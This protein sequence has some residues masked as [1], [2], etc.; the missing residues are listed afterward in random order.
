M[1]T[2]WAITTQS[3]HPLIVD[4][5]F[6]KLKLIQLLVGKSYILDLIIVP[7]S[8]IKVL[9]QN[10]ELSD[11]LEFIKT[12]VETED[13]AIESIIFARNGNTIRESLQTVSE[14]YSLVLPNDQGVQDTVQAELEELE[15]Y[16]GAFHQHRAYIF[17][18]LYK[19]D[20][21]QDLSTIKQTFRDSILN[22]PSDESYVY[23]EMNLYMIT[24][25]DSN[26]TFVPNELHEHY[27]H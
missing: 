6:K 17:Q 14:F 25:L 7:N 24:K 5:S 27:K 4:A 9:P 1:N 20:F 19:I 21:T 26:T 18:N 8:A 2:Y 16:K 15:K 22:P 12:V 11:K 10:K 13:S 23:E 3:K